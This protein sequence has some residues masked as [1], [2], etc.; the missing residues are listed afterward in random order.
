MD[1][2]EVFALACER[3]KMFGLDGSYVAAAA[4]VNGCDAGN[5][6]RLLAGFREWLAVELQDG[7]NLSW[8]ALVIRH[9]FPSGPWKS[10]TELLGNDDNSTA[11]G[12]LFRLLGEFWD[13]RQGSGLSEIF[14]R[15][16]GVF[17]KLAE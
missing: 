11:V 2:K 12:T 7:R 5:D 16:F 10:P 15:Y 13:F 6:W 4:F 9:A 3:P 8:Q 1:Y 14:L 17:G